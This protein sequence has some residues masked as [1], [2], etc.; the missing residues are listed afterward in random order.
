MRR[1]AVIGTVEQLQSG[2]VPSLTGLVIKVMNE[3]KVPKRRKPRINFLADSLAG[4][5]RVTP[6]R[7]RD[8]CDQERMKA[9]RPHH[10]ICYEF[11]VKCSCGYRG[12][13]R[14]HACPECGA[15]IDFGFGSI[16]SSAMA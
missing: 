7:S 11:Y 13:S 4:D 2:F 15:R 16:F 10:I 12:H 9:K 8:I 5:G 3:P 6:R 1:T 14:N